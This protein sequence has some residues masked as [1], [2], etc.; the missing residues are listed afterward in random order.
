MLIHQQLFDQGRAGGN[1]EY[2]VEGMINSAGPF[3]HDIHLKRASLD[4]LASL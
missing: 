4:G 2:E 3:L 1:A